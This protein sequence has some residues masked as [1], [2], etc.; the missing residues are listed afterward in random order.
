MYSFPGRFAIPFIQE[1][2]PGQLVGRDFAS[3][4]AAFL[5]KN[6]RGG[7]RVH[8]RLRL[9]P[10]RL[11]RAF[12]V[13]CIYAPARQHPCIFLVKRTT[14]MFKIPAN[15]NVYVVRFTRGFQG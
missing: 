1:D 5:G 13:A 11:S 8:R 15:I 3:Q 6:F 2:S 9:C 7:A 4:E 14:Y 10:A 12:I